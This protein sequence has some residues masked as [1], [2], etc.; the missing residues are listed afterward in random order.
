MRRTS[1]GTRCRQP[2]A[3]LT[4]DEVATTCRKL[5]EGWRGP[6]LLKWLEELLAD[7]DELRL[8]AVAPAR[9]TTAIVASVVRCE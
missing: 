8:A 4:D 3:P 5:A 9:V 2:L 6:V 1:Q 7:R